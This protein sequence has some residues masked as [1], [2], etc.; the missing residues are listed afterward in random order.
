M[1]PGPQAS[2]YVKPIQ[3]T[4]AE[5]AE[6]PTNGVFPFV[7]IQLFSAA[8]ASAKFQHYRAE[9]SHSSLGDHDVYTAELLRIRVPFDV[10]H[11]QGISKSL[12]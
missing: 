6:V 1:D 10:R 3:E 5:T 7:S 8:K 4:H 9:R 12:F 11:P 2:D